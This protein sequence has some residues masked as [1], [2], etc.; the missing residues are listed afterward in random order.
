M[1]NK[2][3]SAIFIL[4]GGLKKDG[5]VWRTTRLNEDGDHYGPT[6][7][8]LRVLAGAL[9][10]KAGKVQTLI[11][12]GGKG[13]YKD[14]PEVPTLASVIKNELISMGVPV[15]AVEEENESE[16]TYQQLKAAKNITEKLVFTS[17]GIISN[18]WH[19]PRIK[20]LIDHASDLKN[21]NI[22]LISAET[23]ITEI[24]DPNLATSIKR[25]YDSSLFNKRIELEAKGIQD[26]QEGKY[27]FQ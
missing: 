12:S 26:I 13:Q 16:N 1:N 20:A 3:L 19:I 17:V 23:V 8:C 27:K 7:D 10:F 24:G 25:A 18:F 9:L 6:A 4:G 2:T 22:K 11:A 14:N 5:S 21:F 15:E